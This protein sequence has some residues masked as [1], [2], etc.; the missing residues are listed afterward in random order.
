MSMAATPVDDALY[1]YMVDS[2]AGEEYALLARMRRRA[3]VAGMPPISI[4]PDQG[5][6]MK[7]L[8]RTVGA[9]RALDVGTLFG[10]SAA[11]LADGVGPEGR[12]TSFEVSESHAAVAKENLVA[13]GLGDRVEVVVGDALPALERLE[14]DAFDIMLVDADKV[15]YVDYL[16]QGLRLVRDGGILAFDNAFGFGQVANTGL[17]PEDPDS[18]GVLAIRRFNEVFKQHPQVTSTLL[19]VGDGLAVGVLEKPA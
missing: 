13:E 4:S 18:Q 3:D 9:R 2:Y 16:D 6:L 1:A 14:D 10:Y 12:V 19:S 17:D 8:A 5:K 7:V 15:Q 11:C